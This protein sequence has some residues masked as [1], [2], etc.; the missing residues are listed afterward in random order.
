MFNTRRRD[1]FDV[2]VDSILLNFKREDELLLENLLCWKRLL[3]TLLSSDKTVSREKRVIQ[4]F[5]YGLL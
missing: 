4:W 2:S 1:Y 5:S 3:S